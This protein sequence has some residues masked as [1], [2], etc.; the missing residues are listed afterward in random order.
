MHAKRDADRKAPS[1]LRPQSTQSPIF[2]LQEGFSSD[3][4]D[5]W[6]NIRPWGA[7]AGNASG[8]WILQ[9]IHDLRVQIEKQI[10]RGGAV[11]IGP[12]RNHHV[13]SD[14]KNSNRIPDARQADVAK[15]IQPVGSGRHCCRGL[16]HSQFSEQFRFRRRKIRTYASPEIERRPRPVCPIQKKCGVF[17]R[18][19]P[20]RPDFYTVTGNTPQHGRP[21]FDD[22]GNGRALRPIGIR[23]IAAPRD[24][25]VPSQ[26]NRRNAKQE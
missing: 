26:R 23:T 18:I 8:S 4:F 22:S 3:C 7:G 2:P 11:G 21:V 16:H 5:N 24:F 13:V 10:G 9:G 15:T 14:E 17:G 6:L 20:V 12:Q 25:I 19:D 1:P